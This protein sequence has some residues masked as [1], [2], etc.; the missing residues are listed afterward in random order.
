MPPDL[1]ESAR[2]QEPSLLTAG[3]LLDWQRAQGR[4]IEAVA[5]AVLLTHQESLFASLRP[6]LRR[7][8]PGLL[9]RTF[10]LRRGAAAVTVAAG[11]GVGGPATAMAVE[12][13]A[14]LGARRIVAVDA[15]ASLVPQLP[16][17]SLLLAMDAVAAGGAPALYCGAATFASDSALTARLRVAL[18]RRGLSATSGRVWSTDA[19]FRE[20]PSAL[21]DFRAAG[22]GAVDMETATLFAVSAALGLEAA[23]VL[24]IGDTLLDD[25]RPPAD[26]ALVASRLRRA[27]EAALDG[28][29]P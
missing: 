11:F 17:G 10:T 15:A 26:A 27:A 8:R 1:S 25:W 9:A 21:E 3:R 18:E 20:T 16:S 5:S 2:L 29:G 14:A 19:P 7:S 13:L 12:E 28:L 22:A 24:V 23:A 4:R 6:R